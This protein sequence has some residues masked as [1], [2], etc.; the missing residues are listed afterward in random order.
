[1]ATKGVGHLIAGQRV[2][3]EPKGETHIVRNPATSEEIARVALNT[4][5]AAERAVQA[6]NEAQPAWA[7]T[8][9]GDRVQFLFLYKQLL[10][11]NI[12][13]LADLIIAE[14]G[15][16]R[17]EAIGSIRRGIDCV[18]FACGAPA[19]LMGRTLPQIAVSSSFCRAK[20]EGGVGIDSSVDRVPLGVCVGITP[21]NFP[22]MVPMWM[23]PMAI[24]CGNTFVLKPSEKASVS[25]LRSIELMQETGLPEGVLNVVT[26]GPDTVNH[27]ITHDLVRAVSFVGSTLA[28]EYIYKTACAAGKRV[29]CMCG[30]KNHSIVMP[31]ANREA[32]IDGLT[33]SAFGNTGQRCLAGSVVIAVGDSAEWLV[34]ALVEKAKQINVGPGSEPGVTMGPLVDTA[35]CE[36]VLGCIESGINEGAELILDGRKHDLPNAGCFTGPTIFDH[37]KPGMSIVDQEI[38]GP[39]LSIVRVDSLEEAIA[40]VNHSEYGNMSVIF[41]NSGHAARK[42]AST[43]Q[44]GML[45]INV[46]VPAPMAAFPFSGWKRSFF[47]DL[48]ANGEDGARFFTKSRVIVTRWL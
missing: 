5:A 13:E 20:D 9:V 38:F 6:A 39:V 40:A 22:V 4:T 24:A 41:T 29:Q 36:R 37:A 11:A 28:G 42:F 16:T 18:E 46:G 33:G 47:G 1:M 25:T 23:W 10:E 14:H 19:L 15:K 35:S 27:L 17:G 34:P 45:G 2:A 43:V 21:F 31:D 44:A 8:P 30:A 32:A 7:A 12:D 26:G 3:E 48:H